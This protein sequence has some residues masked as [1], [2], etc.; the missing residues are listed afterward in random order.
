VTWSQE[1]KKEID[2]AEDEEK[3]RSDVTRGRRDLAK[4]PP[5]ESAAVVDD[6][7]VD[8]MRAAIAESE[9]SGAERQ[10]G[11]FERIDD[12]DKDNDAQLLKRAKDI[13]H[14]SSSSSS[15]SSSSPLSSSSKRPASSLR[16]EDGRPVVR[17]TS[18]V[19]GLITGDS[20]SSSSGSSLFS[21]IVSTLTGRQP[22]AYYYSYSY[23]ATLF[24]GILTFF[25]FVYWKQDRLR[26]VRD[27]VVRNLRELLESAFSYDRSSLNQPRPRRRLGN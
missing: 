9:L 24:G 12:N 13:T 3:R 26:G 16:D 11:D 20:S 22:R 6:D 17:S 23:Y 25:W 7:D 19:W 21:A 15:S 1:L 18:R 10:E 8:D 2:R 14:T 4:K 5:L 27:T